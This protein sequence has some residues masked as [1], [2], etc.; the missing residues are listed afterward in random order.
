[1][2]KIINVVYGLLLAAYSIYSLFAKDEKDLKFIIIL[3]V[4]LIV[5]VTLEKNK[6]Q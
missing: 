4:L 2:H 3:T 6:Q 1:M 5:S